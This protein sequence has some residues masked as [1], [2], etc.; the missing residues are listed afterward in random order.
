MPS[1]S[2]L[3]WK[4][5]TLSRQSWSK[6]NSD[7]KFVS[8]QLFHS[9]IFLNF[10]CTSYLFLF[11]II[12]NKCTYN[13]VSI[14]NRHSITKYILCCCSSYRKVVILAITE[15][16]MGIDLYAFFLKHNG[17]CFIMSCWINVWIWTWRA[18]FILNCLHFNFSEHVL[19]KQISHFYEVSFI[20]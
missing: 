20:P 19:F 4:C 18:L 13:R 9:S 15:I 16:L 7:K 1:I 2:V 10:H 11:R 8:I 5:S 6:Y 12:H 17:F 3:E 14:H